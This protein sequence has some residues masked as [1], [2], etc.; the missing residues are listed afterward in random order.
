MKHTPG[1]KERAA[2]LACRE[3]VERAVKDSGIPWVDLSLMM[4]IGSRETWFGYAPGYQPKGTCA[5]TGD[6]G[7][8]HGYWQIDDRSFGPWLAKGLWK[9]VD[10]CCRQAIRVLVGKRKYISD[11]LAIFANDPK[12][13]LRA[14]IAAYNCGEGNVVKSIKAGRDVDARTAGGD[15]S[16]DVL[17]LRDWY[18]ANVLKATAEPAPG[19]G[20][21]IQ[22]AKET[23]T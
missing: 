9:N 8:G 11:H 18:L 15:Y 20:E 10:D 6:G 1:P 13:L 22:Q 3:A 17:E 7:H 16:R 19:R 12:L 2:A 4:A 5:G 21:A 14:T 23:M